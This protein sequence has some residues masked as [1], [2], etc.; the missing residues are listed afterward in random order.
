M[1]TATG[2]AAGEHPLPE[3][4]ALA[5]K[6]ALSNAGS[7]YAHSVILLLS[8]HFVRHTQ[9]AITAASRAARCLQ[10]TGCTVPGLFTEKAWALDQPAAAALVLCGPISLG[11]PRSDEALLSLAL[12]SQLESSWINEAA[13]RFGTLATDGEGENE[14]Q[15]WTQG[16]VCGNG[17]AEVGFHGASLQIA[18]SR[19]I[20]MLTP[21]LEVTDSD[22]FEIRQLNEDMALD[23]LLRQLDPDTRKLDALP[24]QRIFA[25][26]PGAGIPEDHAINT[27]RYT[28]LPILRV[29][30]DERSVTLAAPLPTHTRL[31][32]AIREPATAEQDMRA[33]VDSLFR[34]AGNQPA[35]AL[36]FSCIGRGPYFYQGDDRDVSIMRERFPDLPILGA[37]GAGEIA[38]FGAGNNQL[39]SYSSVVGLVR[40]TVTPDV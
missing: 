35:F 2:F 33:T 25:V 11:L 12:H 28:L 31:C 37:Y 30:R 24:P 26:I 39:I 21:L 7:D 19:G 38:P 40:P 20:R 5:I 32:W 4:A 3:L 17:R 13:Q 9:P 27:G 22:N 15:V 34:N 8:G 23:S 36:M 10:V 18:T 1:N 14:G 6:D 16:K 29:N